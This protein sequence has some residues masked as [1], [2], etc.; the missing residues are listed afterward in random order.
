MQA[1]RSS[2]FCV[3]ACVW[4]D[5]GKIRVVVI[6]RDV[7]RIWSNELSDYLCRSQCQSSLNEAPVRARL[8]LGLRVLLSSFLT[9]SVGVL[10]DIV[11]IA[12]FG[13]FQRARAS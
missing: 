13:S 9:I 8:T 5:F 3:A 4:Q 12:D 7:S 1:E 6:E 11:A 2:T 10:D